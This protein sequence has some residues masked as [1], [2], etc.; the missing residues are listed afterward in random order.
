MAAVAVTSANTNKIGYSRN[1]VRTSGGIPYV[2]LE[3]STD[4]GIEVWKGNSATPTSFSEQ[5]SANNPQSSGRYGSPACA[6]DSTDK[7]HIIYADDNAGNPQYRYVVFNTVTDTF[8][9][10][11]AITSD[12][13]SD[14]TSVTNMHCSI[15]IDSNDIPHV[16]YLG[17]PASMGTDYY[18]AYYNNRIGGVWNTSPG[19]EVYGKT[20]SRQAAYP[21][22]CIDSDNYPFIALSDNVSSSP[23]ACIGNANDATS[24]TL[25]TLDSNVG[26]RVYITNCVDSSGDHYVVFRRSAST[27]V[28]EKHHVKTD[29][30]D[31][32][33]S[34]NSGS[35]NFDWVSVSMALK[36]SNTRYVLFENV[37][38]N[39]INYI[40]KTTVASWGTPTTLETGTYNSVSV[41]WSYLN[42]PSY[43]TYGMD[44]VFVDETASPDVLFNILSFGSVLTKDLSDTVNLSEARVVTADK[45]LS[46]TTNLS[47]SFSRVVEFLRTYTDTTNL[48]ESISKA[49]DK[50]SISENITLSD[51]FSSLIEKILEL[52]DN[53]NL[54]DSMTKLFES[55]KADITNLSDLLTKDISTNRSDNISIS[56]QYV[57]SLE[58]LKEDSVTLNDIL[59]NFPNVGLA[60]AIDL[61]DSLINDFALSSSDS[62]SISDVLINAIEKSS[63][64]NISFCDLFPAL[65]ALLLELQDQINL[66][67][68]RVSAL[69]KILEDNTIFNDAI[70]KSIETSRQDNIQLMESLVKLMY[71]VQSDN[72]SLSEIVTKLLDKVSS[73][74]I[75]LTDEFVKSLSI[76]KSDIVNLADELIKEIL[77]YPSD[78]VLL[79]DALT[80][81][82]EIVESD[83][84]TLSELFEYLLI[85]AGLTL[86]LSDSLELS[87]ELS[88]SIDKILSDSVLT[89]DEVSKY[90]EIS[91]ADSIVLT[92]LIS[93][94]LYRTFSDNVGLS[95]S[96]SKLIELFKADSFTLSDVFDYIFE[97]GNELILNLDDTIQFVDSTVRAILLFKNEGFDLNDNIVKDISTFK[98]EFVTLSDIISKLIVLSPIVDSITFDDTI[99]LFKW[100]PEILWAKSPIAVEF[101][102]TSVVQTSL[103]SKSQIITQLSPDSPV[104]ITF[105]FNSDILIYFEATS[106]IE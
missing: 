98:G 56:E 65:I 87:D 32:W 102:F 22:I 68:E 26:T 49:F 69:D 40:S 12:L 75:T 35:S 88:K 17:Y 29:S 9:G 23:Q 10:D 101:D 44:Y 1:V 20:A 14:M 67:D 74:S 91:K 97:T 64:D 86:D 19:L 43:T 51:S 39:D 63:S 90:F 36:D 71:V 30:W 54:S 78:Q 42:N 57:N 81:L 21:Q 104:G 2:V 103:E 8:S 80:K 105:L 82:F 60:D 72:I 55:V 95:D 94:S 92:E 27:N 85:A 11:A 6:I 3:D 48:S 58:L 38:S 59:T 34:G 89:S 100:T 41:R 96:I 73:D 79:S 50:A 93:K 47:E 15:A 62:I 46:D 106:K 53:L 4:G 25:K 5:D 76:T 83:N 84:I 18:T 70:E 37:S 45:A 28:Y 52:S 7:I 13:G 31:T 16:V 24:F 77:K 99:D 33:E 66:S 61:I